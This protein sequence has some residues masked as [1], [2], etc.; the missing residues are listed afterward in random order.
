MLASATIDVIARA[1]DAA[2]KG[3]H[4]IRPPSVQ[5]EG[6]TVDDAYAVQ[7]RWVALK[8]AAGNEIKGHKIGLTSRAMQRQANI[9]EPDYGSLLADMFY[10][11]GAEIPMS[12]FIQPRLECE[13]GF[14]IGRRLAGPNCTIFDVLSATD[15]V[16]PAAE[17]VDGRTHRVDPDTGKPRCV[18]DSIA[19]NAGN[20]AL[21]IGGRPFK[22]M[23]V[24]LRWVSVLCHRNNVI[25]E[26]GVAAAVLNHPA[27]GVAWLANKLAP[28]DIALEPGQFIL[29]GSFTGVVEARSGDVFHI[30]YGPLGT[31]TSRFM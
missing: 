23:D 5:Y 24:D 17:I 2:E 9:D 4:R 11:G 3:R 12:R 7:R 10:S 31:I 20:A 14:V 28:F 30:D 27:N 16:V 13:L 26:S 6:F 22:P 8:V 15:Y 18:L 19:D 21:I 1:Y 29:G 25:E